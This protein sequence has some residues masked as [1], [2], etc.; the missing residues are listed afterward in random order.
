MK[1]FS[2]LAALAIVAFSVPLTADAARNGYRTEPINA[3]DF[4]VIPRGDQRTEG[5]WCAAAD[6]ARRTLGLGWMDRIYVLRGYG[7]SVTTGR[8]TAIQFSIKQP[9]SVDVQ[10]SSFISFGFQPG[11]SESVQGANAQCNYRPFFND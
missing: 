6:Y 7:P 4:E 2:T 9:Q 1:M 10:P 8:R 3:T 5:Y 11:N